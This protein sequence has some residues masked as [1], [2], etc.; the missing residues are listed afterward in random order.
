[1]ANYGRKWSLL[2]FLYI[3]AN[4]DVLTAS[5]NDVKLVGIIEL[6]ILYD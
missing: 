1:M 2:L 6:F 4:V 5:N 3:E